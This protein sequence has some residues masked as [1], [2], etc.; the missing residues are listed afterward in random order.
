[1]H[2]HPKGEPAMKKCLILLAALLLMFAPCLNAHAQDVF[3][4]DVDMLDMGSLNSDDYVARELSASVQGVCVRKYISSSSEL[5]APVRLTLTQMDQCTVI[6][7]RDYGY[8][9]GTFDSGTIYLPYVSDR[10]SPYLVTLYVGN[11]VYAMPFMQLQP[12]LTDNGACLAGVRFCHKEG[13]QT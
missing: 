4:I 2:M 13:A 9:S 5:A 1:M 8:Q 3:V 6:F 7:D 10:T 12:R 11:Y